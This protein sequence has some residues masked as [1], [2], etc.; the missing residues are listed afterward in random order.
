MIRGVEDAMAEAARKDWTH[1]AL[2]AAGLD[3]RDYEIVDG[4]LVEVAPMSL[5]GGAVAFRL[6]EVL[7]A[8]VRGARC[9]Q[10]YLAPRVLLAAGPRRRERRPDLAFV[11]TERIPGPEAEVFEGGPDLVVEVLSPSDSSD[12]PR[13]KLLEDY[14]PA[15]T[16]EGWVVDPGLQTITVLRPGERPRAYDRGDALETEVVPGLRVALEGVFAVLDR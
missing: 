15:G 14:F 11:A 10:T 9:G 2:V 6:A 12:V 13:R 4:D 1:A 8:H 7:G 3:P 16:R 5:A